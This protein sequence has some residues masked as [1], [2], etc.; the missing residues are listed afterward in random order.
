M[1]LAASG[2]IKD[3]FAIY[4]RLKFDYPEDP[5]ILQDLGF[6]HSYTGDLSRPIE[7]SKIAIK[8]HP[9]PTG[10]LNNAM[11]FQKIGNI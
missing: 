5:E 7:N 11:S 8:L 1:N 3:A 9:F 6:A 10:F 2:K 4:E